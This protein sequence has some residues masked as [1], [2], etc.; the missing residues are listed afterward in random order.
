MFGFRAPQE[1]LNKKKEQQIE[2]G[3]RPTDPLIH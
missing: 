1:S 3:E 2:K